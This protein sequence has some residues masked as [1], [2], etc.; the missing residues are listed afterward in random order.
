MFS[1]IE[2]EYKKNLTELDHRFKTY[3]W[4]WAVAVVALALVAD[5]I[6]KWNRWVIYGTIIAILGVLVIIFFFRDFYHE[7]KKLPKKVPNYTRREIYID[8]DDKL[9]IDKLVVDLRK[10]HLTTKDD[11]RTALDYFERR[12]PVKDKGGSL[13]WLVTALIA[14]VSI[15]IL[16]YD[17]DLGGVNLQRFAGMFGSAFALSLALLAPIVVGQA[18]SVRVNGS[19]TELDSR[20]VEDLA[21]V[22]V[23]YDDFKEKLNESPEAKT[24]KKS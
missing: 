5:F 21:F 10:Y 7:R 3:Y 6:L 2:K 13:E 1:D 11:I 9:R 8:T 24:H 23:N 4:P 16:A 15:V 18:I 22:Y 17:D 19:Q 20:L 14:L 12:M